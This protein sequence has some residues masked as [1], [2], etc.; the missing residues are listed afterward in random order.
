VEQIVEETGQ[1]ANLIAIVCDEM[2]KNLDK[3]Q[4]VL[5][6]EDVTRAL[7]SQAVQGALVGWRRLSDD[8]Q[9]A[10]LDRIIVCATVEA[11]EFS[12]SDI[13]QVLDEHHY[14]YT[15]EQLTQ[16]VA[17][18]ELA[19]IIQRDK[20]RYRYCVPLFRERLLEQD[21]TALLKQELKSAR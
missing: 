14:D 2:L 11:G 19:F 9:A 21:V 1:R 8:K 4:R 17:R 5:N 3:Q 13:M 10:R 18:L 16:S 20:S 12:L 15:T 6:Q 7:H